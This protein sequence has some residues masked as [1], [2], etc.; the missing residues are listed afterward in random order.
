M[1]N[2]KESRVGQTLPVMLGEIVHAIVVSK[3]TG[4]DVKVRV[5]LHNFC[6]K[7]KKLFR[8]V[9]L[10]H[11]NKAVFFLKFLQSQSPLAFW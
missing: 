4:S 6:S 1:T 8:F 9:V 3:E 10:R 7:G 5:N 11:D 2:V